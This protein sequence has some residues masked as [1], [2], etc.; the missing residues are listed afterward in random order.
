MN[1][2]QFHEMKRGSQFALRYTLFVECNQFDLFRFYPSIP[3]LVSLL[4]SSFLCGCP[5]EDESLM[6]L[7]S[8]IQQK[9]VL[10]HSCW[11]QAMP[12]RHG[13]RTYGQQFH[14]G[15][16][17]LNTQFHQKSSEAQI[18][19]PIVCFLYLNTQG[20]GPLQMRCRKKLLHAGCLQCGGSL[21]FQCLKKLPHR[22]RSQKLKF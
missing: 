5:E 17:N 10:E 22:S 11:H 3:P 9:N 8:F 2:T 1:G 14:F 15:S 21:K 16:S 7:N 12:G 20:L 6:F 13:R 18:L 4:A 19:E